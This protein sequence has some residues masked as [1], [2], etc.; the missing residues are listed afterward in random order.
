MPMQ[1]LKAA[2]I[3]FG[4]FLM[5][6]SSAVTFYY[7]KGSNARECLAPLPKQ[8]IKAELNTYLTTSARLCMMAK[9][10]GAKDAS[11]EPTSFSHKP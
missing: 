5:I 11:V 6:P 7:A 4:P 2:Q 9:C 3:A 10:R 8:Q 1:V